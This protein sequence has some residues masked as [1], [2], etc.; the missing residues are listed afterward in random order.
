VH[1]AVVGDV[2]VGTDLH[3]EVLPARHLLP[4]FG[5]QGKHAEG[6]WPQRHGP[7]VHVVQPIVRRDMG[8]TSDRFTFGGPLPPQA[9]PPPQ[10]G[11]TP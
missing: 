10:R 1:E 5:K 4:V 7:V 11:F 2:G 9:E 3:H 6:L 8:E